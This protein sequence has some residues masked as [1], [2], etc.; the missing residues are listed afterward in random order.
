M[1]LTYLTKTIYNLI[2]QDVLEKAFNMDE[3]ANGLQIQGKEKVANVAFGVSLNEEFLIEAIK[4]GADA[5]VFHHA[6]DVRTH[7]SLFPIYTQKRLKLIF[8]HNLSIF[9]FHGAL[10]IH[11]TFGNN[12]QI[13]NL[14]PP[15]KLVSD[16][17]EGWGITINLNDCIHLSDLKTICQ[18]Q[19]NPD[20]LFFDYGPQEIKTVG[21]CSG[22][23]KPYAVH[24]E[25]MLEKNIDLF[26]SGETS[27]SAPHK[28]KEAGINYFVCGHYATEVFGVKALMTALSQQIPQLKTKYIDIKNPI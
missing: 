18:E 8:Q 13:A 17:Y 14:F 9:G 28:M 11:P 4:W 23:A 27:E 24:I 2:G 12:S 19:I 7:K 1:K 5:C 6:L 22:A 25:E 3:M 10:D 26:I 15:H 20:S 21:I 16:L